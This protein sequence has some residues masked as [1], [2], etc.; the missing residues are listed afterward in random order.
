MR[1]SFFL[2][3][4]LTHPEELDRLHV[5]LA[6]PVGH[7]LGHAAV[8]GRQSH[9]A[10]SVHLYLTKLKKVSLAAGESLV[11]SSPRGPSLGRMIIKRGSVDLQE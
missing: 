8:R 11:S 4:K 2:S 9:A 7:E 1:Y 6:V 3:S 5:D 10:T